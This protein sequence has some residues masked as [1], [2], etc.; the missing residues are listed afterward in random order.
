MGSLIDR[1]QTRARE[2]EYPN[3]AGNAL[4]QVAQ[5]GL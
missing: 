5:A 2:Q 4:K 1:D 3:T